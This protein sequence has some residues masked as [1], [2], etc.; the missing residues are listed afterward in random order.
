MHKLMKQR[1]RD[2]DCEG[3]IE[4]VLNFLREKYVK[5]KQFELFDTFD[6]LKFTFEKVAY[7]RKFFLSAF[8][9]T[10]HF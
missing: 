9:E 1:F 7:I 3:T 2:G 8:F 5:G 6:Y 4:K 10:P